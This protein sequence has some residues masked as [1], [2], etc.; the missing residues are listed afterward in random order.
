LF[1]P[2]L[3]GLRALAAFSNDR[4]GFRDAFLKA[5]QAEKDSGEKDPVDKVRMSWRRRS[6]FAVLENP[7][8]SELELKKLYAAM[9]DGG[10]QVVE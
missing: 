1:E 4:V 6:P 3:N 10:R 5:V 9:D 8:P 2:K 7:R